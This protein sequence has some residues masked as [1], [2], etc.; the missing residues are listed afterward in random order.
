MLCLCVCGLQSVHPVY[1]E[2][3]FHGFVSFG[4]AGS[5]L[6]AAFVGSFS[7]SLE[8]RFCSNEDLPGSEG[9]RT[10][11]LQFPGSQLFASPFIGRAIACSPP[12]V[13]A[14]YRE[15]LKINSLR[16]CHSVY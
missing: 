7:E 13:P 3:H 11:S 10:T 14:L 1:P 12:R 9:Q 6:G 4:V 2:E 8:T 5:T 15:M 16:P